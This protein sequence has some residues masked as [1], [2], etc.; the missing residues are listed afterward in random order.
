MDH[1]QSGILTEVMIFREIETKVLNLCNGKTVEV[2]GCCQELNILYSMVCGWI[3]FR[4]LSYELCVF[5]PHGRFFLSH[6]QMKFYSCISIFKLSYILSK[7]SNVQHVCK[8]YYAS[9][10][11]CS[12]CVVTRQS[13]KYLLVFL[14]IDHMLNVGIKYFEA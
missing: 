4:F 7:P 14:L 10:K 2:E 6:I 1:L 3:Q 5:Y 11:N 12:N 13:F 9:L 8:Q